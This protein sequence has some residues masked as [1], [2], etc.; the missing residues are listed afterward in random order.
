MFELR[1]MTKS[2]QGFTDTLLAQ[3]TTDSSGQFRVRIEPT[4]T[5]LSVSAVHSDHEP[6]LLE[7]A[8]WGWT[9]EIVAD[10]IELEEVFNIHAEWDTLRR[11]L[12]S[13]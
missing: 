4:T 10:R 8:N 1:F 7:V 2:T 12:E 9:N 6:Y 5:D 11:L 3:T 13:E